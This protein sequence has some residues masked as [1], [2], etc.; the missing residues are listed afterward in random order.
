MESV[1]TNLNI[2]REIAEDALERSEQALREHCRKRPGGQRGT[3]ITLDPNR[4]SFKES[5]IALVFSG[6]YL[7]ALLHVVGCQRVGYKKYIRIDGNSY[8]G[9]L[10][11]LGIT[12]EWVIKSAERYRRLRRDIVHEKAYDSGYVKTRHIAQKEARRAIELI[13]KVAELLRVTKP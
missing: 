5:L 3:I 8:E 12:D 1:V 2:Y 10:R 6:I 7:E 9:K 11:K 4:A 13:H